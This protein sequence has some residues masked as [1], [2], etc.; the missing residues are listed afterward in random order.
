MQTGTWLCSVNPVCLVLGFAVCLFVRFLF[1]LGEAW[2]INQVVLPGT[3][4]S[5]QFHFIMSHWGN[6]QSFNVPGR[7]ALGIISHVPFI[8]RVHSDALFI[9]KANSVGE[10]NLLFVCLLS[11]SELSRAFS[12]LS[13][14]LSASRPVTFFC[15]LFF[16]QFGFPLPG[17][18][19]LRM[20]SDQRS[21][22]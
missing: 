8:D 9:A 12:F 1:S 17:P 20:T 5:A 21:Q 13:S 3:R 10:S 16:P 19:S 15:S 6:D 14:L 18:R 22:L 7:A 4:W 11:G 2:A